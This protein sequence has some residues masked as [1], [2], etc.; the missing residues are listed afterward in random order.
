MP[1]TPSQARPIQPCI[2]IYAKSPP[3]VPLLQAYS[4]C[5]LHRVLLRWFYAHF[6]PSLGIGS[7]SKRACY[8]YD[9]NITA[10]QCLLPPHLHMKKYLVND[11]PWEGFFF[12]IIVWELGSVEKHPHRFP[13]EVAICFV[14][15]YASM[16]PALLP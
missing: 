6:Q 9:S 10:T 13:Q 11:L 1:T 7:T 12:A 16:Q 15:R 8:H 4:T 3:T 5:S 2:N 14:H